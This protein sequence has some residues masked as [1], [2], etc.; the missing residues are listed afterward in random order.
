VGAVA[1]P[2]AAA[3]ARRGDAEAKLAELEGYLD[4]IADAPEG[5]GKR[6]LQAG[7]A[8]HRKMLEMLDAFA[9]AP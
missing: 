6:T 5:P 8:F 9:A 1:D 7:I 2:R 3:S 4:A